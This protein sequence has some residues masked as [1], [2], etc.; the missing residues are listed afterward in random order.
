VVA[1]LHVASVIAARSRWRY[2]DGLNGRVTL[3]YRMKP[4]SEAAELGSARPAP[5]AVGRSILG[6]AD[7]V[8]KVAPTP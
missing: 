2:I 5:S 4:R 3:I 1:R 8:R 6:D 7:I